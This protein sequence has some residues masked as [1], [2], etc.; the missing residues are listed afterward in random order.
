MLSSVFAE[1]K[2]QHSAFVNVSADAVAD[3]SDPK[4]MRQGNRGSKE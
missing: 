3:S 4:R 1:L 2:H